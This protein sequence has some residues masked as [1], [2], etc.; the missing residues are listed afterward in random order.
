M[1][2]I[3]NSDFFCYF[4][5]RFISKTL[6]LIFILHMS[7]FLPYLIHFFWIYTI[8]LEHTVTAPQVC[9]KFLH[10]LINIHYSD[11]SQIAPQVCRKFLYI[12]LNIHYS[13]LLH[14]ISQTNYISHSKTV[15]PINNI[16]IF[17]TVI[18]KSKVLFYRQ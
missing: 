13:D 1:Y 4:K 14:I 8:R 17:E 16:Y 6:F 15:H 3:T 9:H 18:K 5:V 2:L 10:I 7:K 11:L 12:L